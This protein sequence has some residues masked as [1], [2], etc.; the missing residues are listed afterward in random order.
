MKHIFY[1]IIIT[2]FSFCKPQKIS[3]STYN[4][5]VVNKNCITLKSKIHIESEVLNQKLTSNIKIIQDSIIWGYITGPMGYPV[6]RFLANNDRIKII[7]YVNEKY[8]ELTFDSISKKINFQINYF[9]LQSIILNDEHINNFKNTKIESNDSLVIK[10]TIDNGIT[11]VSY[12]DIKINKNNKIE[13]INDKNK[14]IASWK[15]HNFVKLKEYFFAFENVIETYFLNKK[16]NLDEKIVIKLVHNDIRNNE[17]FMSL[18]FD[19]PKKYK[20]T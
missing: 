15:Y 6:I 4:T 18:P 12:F 1:I 19:I 2:I 9:N 10:K 5:K 14:K 3:S 17:L 20:K 16:S 8:S 11:F 7:D 13:I